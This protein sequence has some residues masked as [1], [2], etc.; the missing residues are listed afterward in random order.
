MWV[1]HLDAGRWPV[2]ARFFS[3]FQHACHARDED[4]RGLFCVP[5]VGGLPA[6]PDG[7]TAL[8][9]HRWGQ[10]LTRLDVM[11]YLDRLL[12]Q[13]FPS[14]TLRQVALAVA[15]ELGGADPSLGA[16]LAAMGVQLLADPLALLAE[17][18][19]ER[20]WSAGCVERP[21]WHGGVV[22]WLD[23][24]E[25]ANSAALIAAGDREAVWRRVWQGQVRVLYPFIEEQRVRLV[26]EVGGF[27]RFPLETTYGLVDRAIDLEIGQ[28]VYFLRGHRLP[29]LTWRQL[30][31]LCNMRHSLAHLRPVELRDLMSPEFQRLDRPPSSQ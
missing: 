27:L 28:L 26:P 1:D 13:A 5:L 22:E 6:E 8:A 21:A 20:G 15:T 7:D 14:R 29:D 17:H 11:L 25:R 16:R 23:G 18:A 9:V 30:L 2:W 10:S 3:Q 19:A 4:R 12:P 24:E 31:V